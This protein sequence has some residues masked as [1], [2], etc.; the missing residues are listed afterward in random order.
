MLW[1]DFGPY[2]LPCVPECPYPTL[3]L[4]AKLAAIKFCTETKCWVKRL[5]AFYTDGTHLVEVDAAPEKARMLGFDMVEVAGILWPI[6]DPDVGIRRAQANDTRSFCFSEDVN[7]VQ[8]YPLQLSGVAVVVRASLVPAATATALDSVLE[9]YIEA[10]SYGAI[11]STMRVLSVPG[12]EQFE[13]MFRERIKS[14]S[15]DLACGRIAVTERAVASF[16]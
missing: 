15:S 1:S 10:I 3:E 4:H 5:D 6:V 7:S 14:E 8:I 9:P 11:A 16:M 13:A 2:V 12:S